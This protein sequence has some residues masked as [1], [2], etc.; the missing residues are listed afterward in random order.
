MQ[1]TE[2]K[3]GL[4]PQEL[5]IGSWIY[6]HMEHKNVQVVDVMCDSVNTYESEGIPLDMI[7][8]IELTPEILEKAGFESIVHYTVTHSMTKDIGRNRH[9]SIGCVGTPNEMLFLCESNGKGKPGDL[10]VLHNFDYDG[11]LY[12]HKLMNIF[13]TLTNTELTVNF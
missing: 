12:L 7:G 8:G 11:K 10:I 6:S 3:A 13:H 9:L 4:T 5:R 1:T 2:I